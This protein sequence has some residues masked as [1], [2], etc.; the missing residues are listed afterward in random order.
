LAQFARRYRL[1]DRTTYIHCC[2]LG[3]DEWKMIADSGGSVSLSPQIDL[4]MGQGLAELESLFAKS[5]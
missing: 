3:D 1:N 2:T 4:Q 5:V